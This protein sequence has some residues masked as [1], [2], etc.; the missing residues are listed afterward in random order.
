[1]LVI[2]KLN[3]NIAWHDVCFSHKNTEQYCTNVQHLQ[4]F[5]IVFL[6][7]FKHEY[8]WL[9]CYLLDGALSRR[10]IW[11][12]QH[13]QKWDPKESCCKH[14]CHW[15]HLLRL[16]DV[17]FLIWNCLR[18]KLNRL[19]NVWVKDIRLNVILDFCHLNVFDTLLHS[20][21][22]DNNSNP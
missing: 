14:H 10:F 3:Q 19:S 5:T 18:V 8:F 17:S 16:H 2:T 4:Y 9:S 22:P 1:M 13:H 12:I 20:V 21:C 7:S 15:S 11:F 6:S